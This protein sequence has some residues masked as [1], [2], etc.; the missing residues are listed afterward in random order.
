MTWYRRASSI[1][2]ALL[3]LPVPLVE[4]SPTPAEV[5]TFESVPPGLFDFLR[6]HAQG[7]ADAQARKGFTLDA[8]DSPAAW[9]QIRYQG[10]PVMAVENAAT[11]LVIRLP[12]GVDLL[13]P[14]VLPLRDEFR[15]WLEHGER[16]RA[17][18]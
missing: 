14:D 7:F 16:L 12:P 3:L 10:L 4:A 17:E 2:L 5:R 15:V 6:R 11:G 18:E 9:F 8:G 1:L 13:A